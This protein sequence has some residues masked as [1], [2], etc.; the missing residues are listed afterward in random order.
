MNILSKKY[1]YLIF[2]LVI[3][4]P[5]IISLIL[6]GLN[7]SI[8]FTGGSRLTLT[9]PKTISNSQV[10]SVRNVFSENNIKVQTLEKSKNF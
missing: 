4:I 8:E 5:G 6:Y 1:F 9:F 10:S 3:I 2:S 7:L